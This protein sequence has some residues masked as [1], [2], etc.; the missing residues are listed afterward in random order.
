VATQTRRRKLLKSYCEPIRYKRVGPGIA[1]D[2]KPKFDAFY[3]YDHSFDPSKRIMEQTNKTKS[4]ITIEDDV[5]LGFGVI[6]LDGVRIGKREVIGAGSVVTHDIP[7][8]AVAVGNSAH[9]IK[10]R[11]NLAGKVVGKQ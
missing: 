11:G 2:G 6:V 8:G 7:E 5:W 1:L 4:G 10:M 9:V 3:L